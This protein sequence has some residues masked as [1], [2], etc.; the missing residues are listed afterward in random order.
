MLKFLAEKLE[1]GIQTDENGYYFESRSK[2][3]EYIGYDMKTAELK[4][5]IEALRKES[6]IIN[7][8]EKDGEILFTAEEIGKS[9]E[10]AITKA[11][12]TPRTTDGSTNGYSYGSSGGGGGGGGSYA[13]RVNSPERNDAIYARQLYNLNVD[14]PILRRATIRRERFSSERGRLKPWQ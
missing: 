14:N 5:E 1:Q 11:M 10:D 3:A 6:I 8:L 7:Y 4:I 9:I 2:F 13:Y 12:N